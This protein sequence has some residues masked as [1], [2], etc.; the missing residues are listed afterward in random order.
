MN[1]RLIDLKAR[2]VVLSMRLI[3][4]MLSKYNSGVSV[5]A[6]LHIA[7]VMVSCFSK[8][9]DEDYN[10]SYFNLLFFAL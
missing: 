3:A 4:P 10:H 9:L 6:S 1:F 2:E 8:T 7:S 5:F